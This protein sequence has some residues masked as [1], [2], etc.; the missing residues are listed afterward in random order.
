MPGPD[1]AEFKKLVADAVDTGKNPVSKLGKTNRELM[2]IY[3]P[4]IWKVLLLTKKP[5]GKLCTGHQNGDKGHM[6]IPAK[7]LRYR[8]DRELA[9]A[10]NRPGLTVRDLAVRVRRRERDTEEALHDL[11]IEGR[12]TVET[13]P[14]KR[15]VWRHIRFAAETGA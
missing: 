9:Q 2:L 12:V 3:E 6:S 7:V 4:G 11:L 5:Q 8:L 13:A 10:V 14:G 15:P 1:L